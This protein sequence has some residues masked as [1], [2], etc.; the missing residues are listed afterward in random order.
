MHKYN[1][2]NVKNFCT[3]KE[4]KIC[5][6]NPYG[7]KMNER[8]NQLARSH[9]PLFFPTLNDLTKQD[10]EQLTKISQKNGRQ[11]RTPP[12]RDEQRGLPA[13]PHRELLLGYVYALL[14][15]LVSRGLLLPSMFLLCVAVAL[16]LSSSGSGRRDSQLIEWERRVQLTSWITELDNNAIKSLFVVLHMRRHARKNQELTEMEWKKPML[17]KLYVYVNQ[18]TFTCLLQVFFLRRLLQSVLWADIR[19]YFFS[20]LSDCVVGRIIYCLCFLFF[21]N[22][23]PTSLSIPELGIS[24]SGHGGISNP[25]KNVR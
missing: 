6:G 14:D 25:K 7:P 19:T 20:P 23:Q 5:L 2:V 16:S 12:P 24:S 9:K 17:R 1:S 22:F 4:R 18:I 15:Q 13:R 3:E 21:R 10:S 8:A 11:S